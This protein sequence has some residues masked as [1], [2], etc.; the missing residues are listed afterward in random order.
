[1]KNSFHS[2]FIRNTSFIIFS[3]II[4][5]INSCGKENGISDACKDNSKIRQV[6]ADSL[7]QEEITYT[8][9]CRVY[10]YIRDFSYKKY[11]YNTEGQLTKIE[12]AMMLNP[13]MCFIP[14]ASSNE[15]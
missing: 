6:K 11:S 10:E 2:V 13:L 7:I 3:L 4:I 5:G 14:P 12:E 1:M 9:D 8:G 15:T